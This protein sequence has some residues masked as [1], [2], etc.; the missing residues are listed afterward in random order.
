MYHHSAAYFSF[1]LH[2]LHIRS[3]FTL[4]I[5]LVL[6]KFSY[7]LLLAVPFACIAALTFIATWLCSITLHLIKKFHDSMIVKKDFV[8]GQKVLLYNSRL[9]L[10]SGKLRLSGLVLLLLL[11]LFLM[12]QL[13]SK[14]TPQTRASRST[15]IDLSHSS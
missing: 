11:M 7:A 8:V 14:V 9:G 15:D 4:T 10:M 13:R 3:I 12:V 2:F 5:R 1:A 6:K